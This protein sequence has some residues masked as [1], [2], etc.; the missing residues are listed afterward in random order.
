[1]IKASQ[2][3]FIKYYKMKYFMKITPKESPVNWIFFNAFDIILHGG[4]K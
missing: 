1:M 4:R 3:D 2:G